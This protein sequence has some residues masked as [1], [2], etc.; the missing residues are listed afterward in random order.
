MA[1]TPKIKTYPNNIEAEKSL[2]AA[3]LI[4]GETA[5]DI[6]P[7]QS[8]ELFYNER[9]K[10][11]FGAAKDL[12]AANSP[13][14]MVT[15]YDRLEKD[16]KSDLNMLEYLNELNSYLPSAANYREYLRILK[17]DSVLRRIISA[18]NR[19][20]E[21]AYNSDDETRALAFAEKSIYDISTGFQH[22]A[23]EH[24]KVASEAAL[25]RLRKLAE[26][27]ASLKGVLSGFPI[28]D[29]ITNGF[30]KGDLVIIAARPSVGKTSFAL[31]MVSN[32][33]ENKDTKTTV[34]MFSLEMP[35]IQLAQRIMS[36]VSGIELSTISHGKLSV[37][38][39]EINDL[40]DI[41][42]AISDTRVFVDET[43]LQTPGNIIS[44]C[45]RL[46]IKEGGLDLVIIDYLQ[47]MTLDA[48]PRDLSKNTEIG[49]I[50]RLL[51]LLAREMNCPVIVLSQMSRGIEQR[52]DKQPKLSDLRESGSIE[53]DADVV[54]FLSRENESDKDKP[55]HSILL[56]VAKH[57]NGALGV[58][59]YNWTGAN[60][61]FGESQ[62]QKI[63]REFPTAKSRIKKEV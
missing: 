44:R 54:I 23:L 2:L 25:N 41:H 27:K 15:V 37:M 14:D 19:I 49:E 57:R 60:V 13:V 10:K 46:A 43:A 56:D 7:F 63:N 52:D 11:I 21:E 36:T 30:Q 62:D 24:I 51:K 40:W 17:R 35:A 3:I 58:I 6:L 42:V 20:I 47:L 50:S 22:G 18:G 8:E 5:S 38:G 16:K 12:F 32:M 61:K 28:L 34:A 39:A 29:R 53:Q 31:N 1:D 48:R 33:V 26:N 45:R 59:R 9:H 4:D 55:T